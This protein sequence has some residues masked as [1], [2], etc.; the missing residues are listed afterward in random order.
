MNNSEVI[1]A[2][3]LVFGG[4]IAGV[5]TAYTAA[6]NGCSTVLVTK[7]GECASNFILGFNAPLGMCD[8]TGLY[9]EDTVNGGG[10]INNLNLVKTLCENAVSEIE[11]TEKTGL[12]FDRT[13]NGY[14]LLK[15]LGCTIPR[16]AHIENRTGKITLEKFRL[17]AEEKGVK[18]IS[19]AMLS[20]II[21][22][23]GRAV[24][25]SVFDLKNKREFFVGAKSVVIA[26][27]GIHI[28]TDSTYPV[29]MTGDGYAAAYRAGACLTDMEFIQYEP[30]RCIYP[31][32][33]GI[34]TTLLAKGGKIT[35]RHGE[36]FLLK[37]YSSEGDI[38]KDALAKLIYKEIIG[39]NGTEHGG[40]YL[41]LTDIDE[42]E[43][44]E[45]H[46]LYYNRFKDAGIDI[47]KQKTEVAPC[48]HSFMGGIVIDSECK[49]CVDG[50]FAAGEAAGGIH[51]AN[52]MGGN[53][54]TEV[55]VFGT[56]AGK[57]AA[58][59]AKS[60]NFE[61]WEEKSSPPEKKAQNR[62]YFENIKVKIRTIMSK[63]MG[64]VRNGENLHRALETMCGIED[65]INKFSAFGFDA[66]VS[67]KECENSAVVCKCAI[68][69]AI[70]RKESRG[71]H[72]RSD[73][74][75]PLPEYKKNF[76]HKKD[77]I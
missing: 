6:D 9:A 5:K 8:S 44:K 58:K 55:Y 31:V 62:E 64:P 61:I 14:H 49:T 43:I 67:K 29:S 15:P 63:Y 20:D 28:A 68:K 39:G 38:S 54:G 17:M 52:R 56:A 21:V 77:S 27:G 11:F 57:S 16:L 18:V 76:F 72:F 42:A 71:A 24:G 74:P 12:K 50:L 73:Y 60:C 70:L 25:A 4:G 47:T 53:A 45:N 7:S 34:S 32:K 13:K 30:C 69:G 35:N 37:N 2:D 23:N 41:D 48:A 22:K 75:L 19:D 26:T 65:D 59:Y 36:R 3:V 46:S 66:W 33:L 10:G 1:K 51:G 40:V